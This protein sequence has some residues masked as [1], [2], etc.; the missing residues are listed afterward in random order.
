[1]KAGIE[2]LASMKGN[3][4]IAILGDMLEL[5][6]YSKELHYNIG[7]EVAKNNVDFLITVGTEAKNIAKAAIE[8]NMSE[9]NVKV[10]DTNQEAIECINTLKQNGDVILV[11]ASNGMKFIEIV[12]ALSF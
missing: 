6:E 9:S 12:N 11:K 7:I 5:G 8:N 1:M 3:K 10:F 4:K 2:S